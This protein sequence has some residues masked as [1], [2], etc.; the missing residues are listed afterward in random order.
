[1][2]LVKEIDRS[3]CDKCGKCAR[4][5][6]NSRVIAMGQDGYPS[7]E[8][9][10]KCIHCGHCL[11]ICPSGAISFRFEGGDASGDY[12]AGVGDLGS[13]ADSGAGGP[14]FLLRTLHASR[15]CRF[16][17][18]K[19]VEKEKLERILETMVRS[20]SAG[21]EQN[22]NFYV[23]DSKLKVDA[24]ESETAASYR[25]LNSK[26]ASPFM[27][28]LVASAFAR[29][30]FGKTWMRSRA[31]ADLPRERRKEEYVRML[32]ELAERSASGGMSYYNGATAAILVAS[33]TNAPAFHESFYKADAE[34]AVT[35]GALAAAALGLASCRMGLSEMAFGRDR[36][37]R[38]KFGIAQNERVDG[39][40]ALGYSRLEWKRLP[41]RGPVSVTWM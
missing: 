41:P 32:A 26:A 19:A 15:S 36:A 2:M 4:I 14:E 28:N 13:G 10:T 1:M 5:C 12:I 25:A 8:R 22:R 17:E 18:D 39:I 31:L 11:A 24:L 6:S 40:L 38:E 20:P 3:A 9:E 33:R 30:D 16:F 37:M 29:K 7:F 35:Y 23:F 34:I 27:M 21:N